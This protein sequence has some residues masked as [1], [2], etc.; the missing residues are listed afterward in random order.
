[1]A[2]YLTSLQA[3]DKVGLQ[4]TPKN[5]AAAAKKFL[6]GLGLVPIYLGRGRGRGYRW[7]ESEIDSALEKLR[8]RSR[9][10]TTPRSRS[11]T[12]TSL[13]DIPTSAA[14]EKY[15]LH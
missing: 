7:I 8:E 2:I 14:A 11:K 15:H 6:R 9:P 12:A 5:R 13:F 10:K 4:G 1:M 3:A